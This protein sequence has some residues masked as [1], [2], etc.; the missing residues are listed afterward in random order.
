MDFETRQARPSDVEDIALAHRDSIQSIGAAFYPPEVVDAWQEG[1]VGELYLEAMAGGEVFFIATG[2]VE[3]ASIVLG[4]ASDYPIEGSRHGTSVYV[5]GSA[6]RR[7][8][9]SALVRLAE[10]HAIA[11]GATRIE[12]EASLAGVGFYTAN[13]F[14]EIGRG[15]THLRSGYAIDCIFMRKDLV[16]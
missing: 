12:I 13:G 7:G 8:I 4:F 1:V 2:R 14:T 11:A 3:G 10:A 5:R 15:V 9:G 16:V 6:A